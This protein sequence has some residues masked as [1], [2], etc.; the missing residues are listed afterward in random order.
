[1]TNGIESLG[2]SD[3]TIEGVDFHCSSV[4]KTAIL[5]HA[6]V[7]QECLDYL[8][9]DVAHP[10]ITANPIPNGL[11]G[12]REL[13]EQILKSCMWD[14]SAGVNRRLPLVAVE[15]KNMEGE[16]EKKRLKQF[17]ELKV[18]HRTKA[19]SERYVSDRLAR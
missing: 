10:S 8:Q 1:M 16:A 14:F 6:T 12:R 18:Q 2:Q 5:D 3:V 7:V 17:W 4:L 15:S 13:L 19:F 11:E 9:H